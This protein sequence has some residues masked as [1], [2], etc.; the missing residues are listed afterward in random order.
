MRGGR[1]NN[2]EYCGIFYVL[3]GIAATVTN[4]A[5]GASISFKDPIIVIIFI[6]NQV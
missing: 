2:G 5:Y 3:T 6:S 4:W 1:S